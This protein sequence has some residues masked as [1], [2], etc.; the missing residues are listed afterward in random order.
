MVIFLNIKAF[1]IQV[2]FICMELNEIEKVFFLLFMMTEIT[3]WY[4]HL[5]AIFNKAK[6]LGRLN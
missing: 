5:S 2:F 4:L 3:Y 6:H 1:N